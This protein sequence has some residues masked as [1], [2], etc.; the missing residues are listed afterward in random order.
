VE[1]AAG[2]WV[3]NAHLGKLYVVSG[4]LRH[5]GAASAPMPSLELVMLDSTGRAL[6]PSWALDSPRPD[7][8]LREGRSNSLSALRAGFRPPLQAGET[9]DFEAVAWPLP[10]EADRF[11]IRAA[12][13]DG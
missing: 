6:E 13:T 3:D 2:R 7:A 1:I 9:R 8:S 5:E 4:Q 11:E 10:R 12:E